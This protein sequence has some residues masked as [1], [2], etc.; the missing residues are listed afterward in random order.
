MRVPWLPWL[1]M[2]GTS[3][4]IIIR[5]T[6]SFSKNSVL[7]IRW[8]TIAARCNS[9]SRTSA[10]QSFCWW[11]PCCSSFLPI[12]CSTIVTDSTHATAVSVCNSTILRWLTTNCGAS[13]WNR[14]NCTWSMPYWTT[15]C[16]HSSTR[17]CTIPAA[18]ASWLTR[19]I[20][21]HCVRSPITIAI[22]MAF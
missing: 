14:P 19:T 18:S 13:N 5:C 11:S 9:R 7:T 3:I 17:R 22:S 21:S 4:H 10:L 12:I 20:W 16:L 8:Q 1:F 2:S 6:P 15:A